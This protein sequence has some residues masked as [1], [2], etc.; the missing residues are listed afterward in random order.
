MAI[1]D[2]SGEH[3]QNVWTQCREYIVKPKNA[4][5][6][7]FRNPNVVTYPRLDF[8]I[9]GEEKSMMMYRELKRWMPEVETKQEHVDLSK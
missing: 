6:M 1:T 7:L 4:I 9:L 8:G 2:G 3:K 5:R